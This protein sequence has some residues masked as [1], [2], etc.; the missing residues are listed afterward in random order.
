MRKYHHRLC[1][2]LYM[3]EE[4][5]LQLCETLSDNLWL[6]GVLITIGTCFLEDPARVGVALLVA[7]GHVAWWLAFVGIIC[8]ALVGDVG[9]YLIG[10]YATNFMLRR[11]WADPE[12]IE[13]M[14]EYFRRHAIQTIMLSRFLP[15][16]RM[17]AFGSAGVA[18]YPLP[19]FLLFLTIASAVQ[20][21]L[22][23]KLGAL[24]GEHLPWL[25]E[26]RI[27]FFIFIGTLLFGTL[28]YWQLARRRAKRLPK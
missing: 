12:N 17:L 7:A 18:H 5:F 24:L 16:T 21:T 15:G 3:T 11:R 6:Q 10:R 19:R 9:L 1:G 23:L 20:A 2:T 8:G 28:I 22:F 27:A 26:P 13:W 14:Q 25:K 4:T